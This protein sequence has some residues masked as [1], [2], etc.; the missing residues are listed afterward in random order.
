MEDYRAGRL[1]ASSRRPA[2]SP[3]LPGRVAEALGPATRVLLIAPSTSASAR[4]AAMVE[5][6]RSAGCRVAFT[7][8][9]AAGGNRL[10][11]ATGAQCHP[12]DIADEEAV[13]RSRALI[14]RRWGGIDAEIIMPG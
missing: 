12:V 1:S 10:A 8:A 13:A 5:L 2:P 3:A 7:D 11:Q 9:D 14:I 4:A 6:L